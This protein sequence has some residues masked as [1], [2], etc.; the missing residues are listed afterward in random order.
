MDP[1]QP[2]PGMPQMPLP[3]VSQAPTGDP[4]QALQGGDQPVSEEQRQ[5]LLDM[6]AQIKNKLGSFSAMKFASSN[7]T[8]RLR[9]ELLKQVFEKLQLAGVDL[10]DTASVAKFMSELRSSSPELA[11]NFE[12]AMEVLLGG[13]DGLGFGTPPDPNA[14]IDLGVSPQNNMNNQNINEAVSQGI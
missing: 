7:K 6:I 14:T 5:A 12:K 8:E 9:R 4:S 13:G 3:G 2:Q 10:T 1:N 11:D